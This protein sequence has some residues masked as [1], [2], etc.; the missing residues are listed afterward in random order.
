MVAPFKFL[1]A[2]S[3]PAKE[4]VKQNSFGAVDWIFTAGIIHYR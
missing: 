2:N 3:I 1:A 4:S